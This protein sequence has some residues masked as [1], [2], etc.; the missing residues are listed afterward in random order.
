M[1]W[2]MKKEIKEVSPI[3]WLSKKIYYNTIYG[4]RK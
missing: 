2:M 1:V 4:T 3:F